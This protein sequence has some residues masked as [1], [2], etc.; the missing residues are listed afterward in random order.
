MGGLCYCF[1]PRAESVRAP[2]GSTVLAT[3]RPWVILLL[4]GSAR[5]HTAVPVSAWPTAWPQSSKQCC[6]LCSEA[7]RP[8]RRLPQTIWASKISHGGVIVHI[9]SVYI[10]AQ[11]K[12]HIPTWG[13]SILSHYIVLSDTENT[14]R[15]S[16]PLPWVFFLGSEW[17]KTQFFPECLVGKRQIFFYCYC[18][19]KQW[20]ECLW[21]C[22]D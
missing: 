12:S 10:V 11:K 15:P 3:C 5:L 9:A 18:Y 8:H 2:R 22:L 21:R 1:R 7:R 6:I 13:W 19:F 16:F 4:W 20:R 14:I 17:N